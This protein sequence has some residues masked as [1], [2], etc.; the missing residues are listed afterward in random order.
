MPVLVDKDAVQ[1]SLIVLDKRALLAAYGQVLIATSEHAAFQRDSVAVRATF[2][3]GAKV[4]DA[5]RVV[6]VPV[7]DLS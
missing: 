2:R 4:S 1:W 6:L 7:L 5:D 3:F